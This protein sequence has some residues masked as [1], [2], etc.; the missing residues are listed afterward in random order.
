MLCK[1]LIGKLTFLRAQIKTMHVIY[2]WIYLTSSKRITYLRRSRCIPQIPQLHNRRLIVLWRQPQLCGNLRMPL[3]RTPANTRL[4]IAQLDN[5][6]VLTQIPDDASWAE[7]RRQ[8]ML[9]LFVPADTLDVL[10]GLRLRAGH[11]GR[12]CVVQ[13][14]N[15]DLRFGCA[16]CEEIR[17]KR[18]EVEGSYG[19]SVFRLRRHDGILAR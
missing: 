18:I 4:W 9:D 14:P 16:R 11:H 12:R 17:L 10:R 15:E 13:I 2:W 1:L 8:D 19:A 6:F 7:H 3:Q 5:G